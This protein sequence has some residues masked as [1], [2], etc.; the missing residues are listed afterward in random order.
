VRTEPEVQYLVSNKTRTRAYVFYLY[1][2]NAF[3]R[4]LSRQLWRN[5]RKA[6]NKCLQS[7]VST[8]CHM[9]TPRHVIMTLITLR[10]KQYGLL[11]CLWKLEQT[12]NVSLSVDKCP[13]FHWNPTVITADS[14]CSLFSLNWCIPIT[15]WL[16]W[17]LNALLVQGVSDVSFLLSENLCGGQSRISLVRQFWPN[18][19]FF[20]RC[21]ISV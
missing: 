4:F 8:L 17:T 19:Y 20:H 3:I 2:E 10:E 6:L 1:L 14:W 18:N 5:S 12:G 11:N 7:D 21:A 9:L 16:S 15:L 13:S